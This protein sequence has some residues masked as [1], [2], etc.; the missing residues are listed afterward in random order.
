[1]QHQQLPG[2]PLQL[3]F[4]PVDPFFYMKD[5]DTCA[6][7]PEAVLAC[8]D[9]CS[10]QALGIRSSV[11]STVHQ[12]SMHAWAAAGDPVKKMKVAAGPPFVTQCHSGGCLVFETA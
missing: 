4:E 6:R 12:A 8:S 1:M 7:V 3:L 9:V 10:D 2:Q 5:I 11:F